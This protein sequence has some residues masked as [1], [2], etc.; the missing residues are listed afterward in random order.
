M[1]YVGGFAT[2]ISILAYLKVS[3]CP[4]SAGLIKTGPFD[5]NLTLPN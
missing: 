5:I 1:P 4:P 2:P 3:H